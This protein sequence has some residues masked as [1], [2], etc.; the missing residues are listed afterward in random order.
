[1]TTPMWWGETPAGLLSADYRGFPGDS[2]LAEKLA[3]KL[4]AQQ[5][6]RAEWEARMDANDAR[7]MADAAEKG[8]VFRPWRQIAAERREAAETA[9]HRG[10]V[11]TIPHVVPPELAALHARKAAQDVRVGTMTPDGADAE[12]GRMV[13]ARAD[14]AGRAGLG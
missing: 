11:I 14:A 13:R 2:E 9:A 4:Q 12:W 3:G 1:M 8:Y 6:A 10:Q 5:E 7:L